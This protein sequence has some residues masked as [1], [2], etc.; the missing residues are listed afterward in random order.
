MLRLNS[1]GIFRKNPDKITEP[2]AFAQIM[3][4]KPDMWGYRRQERWFR[5]PPKVRIVTGLLEAYPEQVTH[6]T[7]LKQTAKGKCNK[8]SDRG[9]GH[10]PPNPSFTGIEYSQPM[11]ISNLQKFVGHLWEKPRPCLVVWM[12]NML[13]NYFHVFGSHGMGQRRDPQLTASG[14]SMRIT[15]RTTMRPQCAS[16]L[17]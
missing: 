13:W 17:V 10:L 15:P 7:N 1:N 12:G 4:K 11:P 5:Q 8:N 2:P 16:G 6:V 3:E 9:S 14:V